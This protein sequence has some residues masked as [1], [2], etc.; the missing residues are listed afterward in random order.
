MMT[1]PIDYVGKRNIGRFPEDFCFQL[2]KEE[3]EVLKCQIGT[4]KM[5]DSENTDVFMIGFLL[6]MKR[7]QP[8]WGLFSL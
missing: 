6:L 2:K 4:S 1:Q 8:L 7:H 3:Y 5:A